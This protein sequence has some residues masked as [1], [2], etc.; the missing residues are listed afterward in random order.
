[1]KQSK[2]S[3]R[4]ALAGLF[5]ASLFTFSVPAAAH[6]WSGP[7]MGYG[8][9][10]CPGYG[11]GHGMGPH[12]HGGYACP[13]GYAKPYHG[14]AMPAGRTLGVLVAPLDHAALDEMGL[15]YGMRVVKVQS[16]SA[17]EAA[18]IQAED[19]I[20]E[21]D[22]KPVYSG[23]R[24]RWLV[25]K[26]DED[27]TVGIKLQRDKEAITLSATPQT[28]EPKPKCEKRPVRGSST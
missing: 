2:I 17:A 15:G 20:L 3:I 21:F 19:I 1:M 25:R 16:G 14:A 27:R 6:D 11:P 22:G 7:G 5:L 8:H 26:G 9:P 18:G 13:H 23:E 24:L 10:A 28:P 12:A 4:P